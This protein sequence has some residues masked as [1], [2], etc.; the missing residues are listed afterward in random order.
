MKNIEA[1]IKKLEEA[2]R[3]INKPEE[4]FPVI[5]CVEDAKLEAAGYS[6]PVLILPKVAPQLPKP[7][8]SD[9]E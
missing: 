7:C 8:S 5:D 9:R 4:P 3:Q 1:R 6:G 2:I